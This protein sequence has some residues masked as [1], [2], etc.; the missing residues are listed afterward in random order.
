[1]PVGPAQEQLWDPSSSPCCEHLHPG[2]SYS[3]EEMPRA[4]MGLT[5]LTDT[6]HRHGLSA[7]KVYFICLSNE[8][9][10]CLFKL[11]HT[12]ANI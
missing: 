11:N 4:E 9:N 1:M 8:I 7:L 10:V 6:Y 3:Q 5:A 12:K 2:V